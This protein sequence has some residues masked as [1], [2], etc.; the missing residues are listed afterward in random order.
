MVSRHVDGIS[1]V[2]AIDRT[3]RSYGFDAHFLSSAAVSWD[4]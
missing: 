3:V 1:P 4:P 2:V